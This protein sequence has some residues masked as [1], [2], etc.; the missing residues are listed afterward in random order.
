[1]NQSLFR[2]ISACPTA[3]HTVNTCAQMLL[4]NGFTRLEESLPRELHPGKGY[5]VTRGGSSLVAFRMP[6]GDFTGFMI[7]AAH[8]D[9]PAFEVKENAEL[10]GGSYI[11]LSTEKY[12]GM[13]LS[14]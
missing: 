14:T 11:R 6:A 1:M 10:E 8:G 4:D 13:I 3:Y 9:S 2:F 7:A 12:G 5:F